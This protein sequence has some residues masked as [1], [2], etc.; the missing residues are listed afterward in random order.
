MK[1][2]WSAD[3]EADRIAIFQF[4]AVDNPAAAFDME[5]LFEASAAQLC[6]FPEMGRPGNVPN[7]RELTVHRN[8]RIVYKLIS[9]VVLI[10]NII[11]ARRA[12][13]E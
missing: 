5:E 1:L 6:D 12:W 7:T 10:A 9:D 4:I 8:Y 13:P 11:H 3:A 2:A